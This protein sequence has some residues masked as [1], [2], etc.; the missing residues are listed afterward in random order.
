MFPSGEKHW[1]WKGGRIS[2]GRG[3]IQIIVPPGHHLRYCT[4]HAT[5]HRVIAEQKIGRRLSPGEIVHHINGNRSD[6]RPENLEVLED[7]AHHRIK[8]RKKQLLRRGLCACGCGRFTQLNCR[9][10]PKKRIPGHYSTQLKRRN[11]VR[12]IT[13]EIE[14]VKEINGWKTIGIMAEEESVTVQAIYYRIRIG[15]YKAICLDK[16]ILVR[17]KDV[18]RLRRREAPNQNKGNLPPF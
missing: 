16:I 2:D 13:Q 3:Y 7:N 12:R 15:Q 14:K 18:K 10:K 6:N 4:G 17:K 9:K 5:E 1:N 11:V 8:H